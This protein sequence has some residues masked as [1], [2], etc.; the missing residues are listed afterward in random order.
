LVAAVANGAVVEAIMFL[1]RFFQPD[2]EYVEMITRAVSPDRGFDRLFD[3][4]D[5]CFIFFLI[6]SSPPFG[7][8][9]GIYKYFGSFGRNL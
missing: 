4:D 9:P 7:T 1:G 3:G 2:V 8:V 6:Q 5:Q